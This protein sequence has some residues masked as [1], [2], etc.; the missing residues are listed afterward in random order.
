MVGENGA[1]V[2]QQ[3]SIGVVVVAFNS[4]ETIVPCLTSLL[5]ST[6]V[7]KV[8]VVDNGSADDTLNRIAAQLED[9]RLEV[10]P[11]ARNVGFSRA[12]NRGAQA[13]SAPLLALVNPDAVAHADTLPILR[14]ALQ[15]GGYWAVG[16]ALF[17]RA[18]IR[19]RSARRFPTE[20]NALFNWRYL[21]WMPRTRNRYVASFLMLEHD[22]AGAFECEWLS[23]AFVLVRRNVFDELGGFNPAYFLYYEEVDLFQR[24]R[25]SGY[26]CAFVG[27]ATADHVI[28]HS[29]RGVPVR[30]GFRRVAG[31]IRYYRTYL[32]PGLGSD[33]RFAVYLAAGVF[34]LEVVGRLRSGLQRLMPR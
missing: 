32:R 18:G 1:R 27:A 22:L 6:L 3:P 25:A 20:K 31:F 15:E 21:R 29:A 34:V 24:A 33:F 19:E 8:V 5:A 4:A 30:A 26:R 10:I 17:N 12:T 23:G 9:A 2:A 16:P 28:G 7:E 14:D 13:T 11:M